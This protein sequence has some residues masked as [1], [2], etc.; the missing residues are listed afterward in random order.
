VFWGA[1]PFAATML[2]VLLIVVFVPDLA[3]LLVR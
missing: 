2:I 1:A 3:T